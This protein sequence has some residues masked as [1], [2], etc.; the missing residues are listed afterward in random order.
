MIMTLL[1]KVVHAYKNSVNISWMCTLPSW[2]RR[3]HRLIYCRWRC[4]WHT[5]L[6]GPH[7]THSTQSDALD[8]FCFIFFPNISINMIIIVFFFSNSRFVLLVLKQWGEARNWSAIFTTAIRGQLIL[9]ALAAW[10]IR[11]FP[12][13]FCLFSRNNDLISAKMAM[14]NRRQVKQSETHIVDR[15]AACQLSAVGMN[16]HGW[17]RHLPKWLAN[18]FIRRLSYYLHAL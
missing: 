5:F 14:S 4:L 16:Q 3:V 2:L 15:H 11:T 18:R 8:H 12:V 6:F 17:F 10:K 7:P 13:F 9:P 1:P